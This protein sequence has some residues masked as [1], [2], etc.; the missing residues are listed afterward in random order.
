MLKSIATSLLLTIAQAISAAIPYKTV[1]LT[2]PIELSCGDETAIA[3]WA[4]GSDVKA[5]EIGF[6][7]KS[8]AECLM[9]LALSTGQSLNISCAKTELSKGD[10]DQRTALHV[11]VDLDNRQL[12]DKIYDKD[13]SATDSPCF[14]RIERRSGGATISVGN[15]YLNKLLQLPQLSN[16]SIEKASVKSTK[17]SVTII[18]RY[19]RYYPPRLRMSLSDDQLD[20][21]TYLARNLTDINGAVWSYIDN[22]LDTELAGRGGDY[23]LAT[24]ANSDGGYDIVYLSGAVVNNSLWQR[25]DIKGKMAPSPL[26]SSY[27]LTWYDADLNSDYIDAQANIDGDILTLV[28]PYESAQL[29]FIRSRQ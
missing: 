11:T 8:E 3:G 12:A 24:V 25:G 19:A 14:F 20:Q 13:I 7:S 16:I 22:Q 28:F 6:S 9:S 26:S 23:R 5:V 29:R 4:S 21:L 27:T 1:D 2:E 17:N 15:R 10:F 18:R